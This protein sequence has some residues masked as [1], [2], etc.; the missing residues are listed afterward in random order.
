MN[1]KSKEQDIRT[2]VKVT[3]LAFFYCMALRLTT[4]EYNNKL[5]NKVTVVHCKSFRK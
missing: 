2:N 1:C 5:K 3:R 4:K